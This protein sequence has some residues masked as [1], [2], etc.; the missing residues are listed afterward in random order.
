VPYHASQLY[1]KNVTTFLQYL[2]HEGS[3]N[4]DTEDEIVKSTLVTHDGSLVHEQIANA[5]GNDA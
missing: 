3:L 1:S 5:V 2:I 4:I